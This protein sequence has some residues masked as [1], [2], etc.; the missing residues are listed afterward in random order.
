MSLIVTVLVK[1]P[2]HLNLA[3]QDSPPCGLCIPPV[4]TRQLES[5]GVAGCACSFNRAEV[6]L[7]PCIPMELE[8]FQW[9]AEVGTLTGFNGWR[10][11]GTPPGFLSQQ[12]RG[13]MQKWHP[14]LPLSVRE[15]QQAPALL[16]DALRLPNGSPSQNV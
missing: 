10:T 2:R 12:S 3:I 4:L 14:L 7:G 15:P 8:G 1:P 6:S 16:A 5:A 13:R 11:T 9:C